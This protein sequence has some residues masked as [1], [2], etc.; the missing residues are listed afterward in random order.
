MLA[1]AVQSAPDDLRE[2]GL[3][4]SGP[5]GYK[6]VEKYLS[7]VVPEIFNFRTAVEQMGHVADNRA[8]PDDG[9]SHSRRARQRTTGWSENHPSTKRNFT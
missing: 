4:L 9:D 2:E 5:G 7:K 1:M 6:R 3:Q 8:G